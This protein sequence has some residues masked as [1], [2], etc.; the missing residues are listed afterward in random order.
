MQNGLY[1][2]KYPTEKI[3]VDFLF[4]T[5]SVHLRL[6][7][8]LKTKAVKWLPNWSLIARLPLS[9][10]SVNATL[11]WGY[12]F[13]NCEFYISSLCVWGLCVVCYRRL[14]CGSNYSDALHEMSASHMHARVISASSSS[15][16]RYRWLYS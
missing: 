6:Q 7:S 11:L 14:L 16:Y 1:C 4:N 12:N 13:I 9:Y 5:S 2:C 3:F 15:R 8:Q 10:D